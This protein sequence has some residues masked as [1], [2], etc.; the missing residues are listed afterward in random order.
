MFPYYP[1][2]DLY[3]FVKAANRRKELPE[4]AVRVI[5]VQLVKALQS[6]HALGIVHRDLKHQN[7]LV[8][9]SELDAFDA[10]TKLKEGEPTDFQVLLT[11][12]GF[13]IKL[14]E[15]R[16]EDRYPCLGTPT[17]FSYE[18]L[19]SQSVTNSNSGSKRKRVFYDE[20]VDIW[21][22]GIILYSLLFRGLTP[23]ETEPFDKEITKQ[24]IKGLNYSFPNDA[25]K[26]G[27]DLIK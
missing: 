17:H 15:L 19:V 24:K 6:L 12:F 26:D 13:A 10:I 23:F 20:R 3:S 16:K 8:Q 22:L 14:S 11:D 2:G 18:M 21:C 27:C 5:F 7:I 4:R 9:S 1:H 25:Y